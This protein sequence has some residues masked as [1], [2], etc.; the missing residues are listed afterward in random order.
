MEDIA[1][2]DEECLHEVME[3]PGCDAAEG[4][5]VQDCVDAPVV[6]PPA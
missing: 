4:V 6:M 5:T 2:I 1:V 3:T